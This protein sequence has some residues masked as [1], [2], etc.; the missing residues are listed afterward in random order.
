MNWADRPQTPLPWHVGHGSI[1]SERKP[2]G[3]Y[4][5]IEDMAYY[6]GHFV[7]E[8]I[9]TADAEFIIL[10]IQQRDAL[11]RFFSYI[12]DSSYFTTEVDQL[13]DELCALDLGMRADKLRSALMRELFAFSH[14]M[15][16]YIRVLQLPETAT[17][18]RIEP[19]GFPY[20]P[21]M[22]FVIDN[23]ELAWVVSSQEV[24]YSSPR[25][26]QFMADHS[27]YT[28]YHAHVAVSDDDIPF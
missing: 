5:D 1:V 12:R 2:D 13:S 18:A 20:W 23:I 22:L 15:N 25:E 11:M 28:R 14:Y 9:G 17:R 3:S 27:K 19:T 21:S 16:R 7:C 10:A 8:S 6:G 24:Y 26:L 4:P